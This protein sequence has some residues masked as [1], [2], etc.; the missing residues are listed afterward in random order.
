MPPHHVRCRWC[1]KLY[2]RVGSREYVQRSC[3]PKDARTTTHQPQEKVLDE[4]IPKTGLVYSVKEELSTVLC[5]PKIMPIKSMTLEK[6]ERMQKELQ[7]HAL[8]SLAATRV[9]ERT[10][11]AHCRHLAAHEIACLCFPH[12]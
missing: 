10:D 1:V 11:L 6:I 4:I 5:K 8:A 3:K 9:H 12:A 2:C 7:V